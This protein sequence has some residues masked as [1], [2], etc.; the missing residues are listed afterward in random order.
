MKN[1]NTEYNRIWPNGA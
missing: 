1:M